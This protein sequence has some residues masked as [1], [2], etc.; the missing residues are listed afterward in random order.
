MQQKTKM[1]IVGT[2]DY[3][4]PE[5]IKGMEHDAAADIWSFGILVYEFLCGC[6]PFNDVSIEK[7]FD[8]ILNM[9]MEWPNVGKLISIKLNLRL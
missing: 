4:A 8:N 6:P 3:I 7:V 1:R 9:R 5:I 2:P